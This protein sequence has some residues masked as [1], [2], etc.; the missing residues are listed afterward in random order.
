MCRSSRSG[1]A[2]NKRQDLLLGLDHIRRKILIHSGFRQEEA[3][4]NPDRTDFLLGDQVPDS[5]N[6]PAG[7]I[8]QLL[9]LLVP[10]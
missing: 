2:I 7:A 4:A 1:G 10:Y 5:R 9:R 8:G 3:S 6:R